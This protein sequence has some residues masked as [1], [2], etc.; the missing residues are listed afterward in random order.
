MI[1]NVEKS[2]VSVSIP[3]RALKDIVCVLVPSVTVI[4]PLL[5]VLTA[6][7]YD[8][9]AEALDTSMAVIPLA[10]VKLPA[11]LTESP[12]KDPSIKDEPAYL[13]ELAIREISV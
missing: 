10:A 8:V 6:T 7:L 11:A 5:A 2:N 1:P 4:A 3:V 13:V 12:P 9:E